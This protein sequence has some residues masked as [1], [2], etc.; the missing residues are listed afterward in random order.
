MSAERFFPAHRP[1]D[2]DRG[3]VR[4]DPHRPHHVVI[5]GGSVVQ[6][7]GGAD[8][9]P[10]GPGPAAGGTTSGPGSHQPVPTSGVPDPRAPGQ[11]AA[12]PADPRQDFFVGFL[13]QALGQARTTF[14]LS[15]LFMSAG[16]VLVLVGGALALASAGDPQADYLPVATALGGVM[17]TG[18]GGAFALRADRARRHLAEQAER[19]HESMRA[20]LTL[21][22][23][24]GLIDRVDDQ[25]LRDRLKSVTA[26]RVLGLG[27]D[28]DTVTGRLLPQAVEPGAAE[29]ERPVGGPSWGPA[30][31]VAPG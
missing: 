1:V 23:T 24:L 3:R 28:P 13:G 8:A 26:M 30:G 31:P 5:S 4:R 27:P 25:A 17:I 7:V 2:H 10:P 12:G 19:V 20:D 18:G 6:V 21:G 22:Q 15:A 11:V 9:P 29:G 14:R 16:A